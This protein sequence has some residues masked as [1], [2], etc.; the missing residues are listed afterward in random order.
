MTVPCFGRMLSLY[1]SG[2]RILERGEGRG[3]GLRVTVTL[4]CAIIQIRSCYMTGRSTY[5]Q[6]LIILFFFFFFLIIYCSIPWF[7]VLPLSQVHR[8]NHV[9]KLIREFN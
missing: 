3:G 5:F 7:T 2:Y 8:D 4:C 6:I 1:R 9:T